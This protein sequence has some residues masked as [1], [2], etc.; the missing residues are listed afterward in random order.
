MCPLKVHHFKANMLR[1]KDHAKTD[2]ATFR[3]LASIALST[4]PV[5]LARVGA[6]LSM[7]VNAREPGVPW[8]GSQI[9]SV[10][11]YIAGCLIN[12]D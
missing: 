7:V 5:P 2:N 11:S 6:Y 10:D 1:R 12:E 9:D 3:A 8:I 4:I